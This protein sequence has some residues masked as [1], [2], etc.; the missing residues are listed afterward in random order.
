MGASPALPKQWGRFAKRD[1]TKTE[2]PR[3]SFVE[4]CQVVPLPRRARASL[5]SAGSTDI[6]RLYRPS[7]MDAADWHPPCMR[8]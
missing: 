7:R 8:C 2:T 4:A 6:P 5:L 3:P 1:E